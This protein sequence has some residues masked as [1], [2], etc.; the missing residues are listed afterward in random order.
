MTTGVLEE[1]T[2]GTEADGTGCGVSRL[3]RGRFLDERSWE[4][5]S[6]RASDESAESIVLR[7]DKQMST[8]IEMRAKHVEVYP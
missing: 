4:S 6:V 1:A 5:P 2:E 3:S 7:K 8:Y